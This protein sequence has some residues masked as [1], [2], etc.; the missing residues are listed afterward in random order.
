MVSSVAIWMV[1][2]LLLCVV[3][4]GPSPDAVGMMDATDLATD[5]D[6]PKSDV[7]IAAFCGDCHVFPPPASFPR[8][9]WRHEVE[10][11]FQIYHESLRTDLVPT[12]LEATVAWFE[13]HAPDE[14][15]FT[16]VGTDNT[17]DTAQRFEKI[18]IANQPQLRSVTHL[19]RL[20]HG[21]FLVCDLYSGQVTRMAIDQGRIEPTV[22][23]QVADPVH[24]EP[25]DLDGDGEIDYL[26]A[27]MGSIVPADQRYGTLCWIHSNVQ[28]RDAAPQATDAANQRWKTELL[29]TGLSR[30][31]DARPIDYDQDGDQDIVV[32]EFGFRFEGAIHLLTNTG[33]VDGIPQFQSRVI[34]D[35]NGAIH[36]PP[37]DINGDGRMDIV[38][39]VSQQHETMDVHLNLGNGQFDTRRIFAAADP[40]YAS[41]G[42]EV[43]DL[44]QDGDLDILYTNGDT[45]DDHTAKPF[46]GIAWLENEGEFPFTH[47]RLTSMPGVY[48]AVVGDIDLDGDLDIAA[49]ALISRSASFDASDSDR[50]ADDRF[51]GAIWLEQTAPGEFARHRLLSGQ[52]DWA[53]C[54]LMD[55]DG[56]DDLD[57]LLGRYDQDTRMS[58][59]VV[60]FRNRTNP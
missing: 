49:V 57:L 15:D 38:T 22:L 6:R 33:L 52:C 26:V 42:I 55:L 53:S 5:R 17:P 12:D 30:V 18:E 24:S 9:R 51:D 60:Y 7:A 39:L 21:Q 40:A 35:R 56:D 31:C 13:S 46:H 41:S 54:E 27:D 19:R 47:H 25:T 23:T 32:A 14:Y 28:G 34:D 48:R 3:G 10:T 37:V 20:D 59:P 45:F 2:S 58:D 11:A 44:D 36:V 1:G 50:S 4:C 43:T 8:H 29:Q 16:L